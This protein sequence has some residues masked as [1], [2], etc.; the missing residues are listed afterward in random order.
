MDENEAVRPAKGLEIDVRPDPAGVHSKEETQILRVPSVLGTSPVSPP[1]P[2][3][4]WPDGNTTGAFI[5]R[6]ASIRHEVS[7]RRWWDVAWWMILL[8]FVVVGIP[9]AG[10]VWAV[11]IIWGHRG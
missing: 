9:A 1:T 2:A 6:A 3:T 11:L 5:S 7:P 4:L 10:A 8:W